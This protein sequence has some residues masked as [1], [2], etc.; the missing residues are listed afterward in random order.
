MSLAE[1]DPYFANQVFPDE[2]RA[3]LG[4]HKSGFG[5]HL[6]KF[7]GKRP[8]TFDSVEDRIVGM[9]FQQKLAEQFAKWVVQRRRESEV[10]IYM[11]DYVK[12]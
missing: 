9:L 12:A 2:G 4:C 10:I 8:V 5:Y 11:E 6:V 1:L 3:A 7:L